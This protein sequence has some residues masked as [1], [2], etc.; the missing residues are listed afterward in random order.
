MPKSNFKLNTITI[1]I[2]LAVVIIFGSFLTY[3]I[4]KNNLS[5]VING[6]HTPVADFVMK[7][8]THTGDGV[9][10]VVLGLYWMFFVNKKEAIYLLITYG[11]SSLITQT[12][13]RVYFAEVLRPVKILALDRL[14]FI[15]GVVLN[16]QLSFPSGHAT[17]A[18]AIAVSLSLIIMRA[19]ISIAFIALATII[20]LSRVYLLQHFITD[21]IAGAIIGSASAF[22]LFFIMN[23]NQYDIEKK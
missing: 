19:R 6:F 4:G 5:Y 15:E 22:V 3:Y 21:V 20:A 9:F 10:A 12:L 14:H 18:F 13:K 17:T 8:L 16:Q 11:V 1:V 2:T 23:M 7:Y